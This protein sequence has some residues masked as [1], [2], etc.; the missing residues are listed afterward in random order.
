MRLNKF[1]NVKM[2]IIIRKILD[3][4]LVYNQILDYGDW[5]AVCMIHDMG[6]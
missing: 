1:T 5:D 3:K 4:K 2:D 6:L